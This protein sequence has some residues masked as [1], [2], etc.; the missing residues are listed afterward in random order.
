MDCLALL[1]FSV[2]EVDVFEDKMWFGISM[3]KRVR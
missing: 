3:L 2:K 1:D